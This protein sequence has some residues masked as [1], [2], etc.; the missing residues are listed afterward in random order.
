MSANSNPTLVI[1]GGAFHTPASYGKLASA[2]EAHGFEVH[3]PRLP[4]RNETRPPNA[5]LTD[6]PV[7][8][9]SYVESLVRA[10]RTVVAIGHTYGVQAMSN[11]LYACGLGLEA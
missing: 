4:T 5:D 11:A 6:D 9:R 2:L 7:L 8:I 3:V 10:G 1:V